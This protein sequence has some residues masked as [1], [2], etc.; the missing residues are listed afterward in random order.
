MTKQELIKYYGDQVELSWMI[1]VCGW[2]GLVFTQNELLA[3]I[4]IPI[5]IYGWAVEVYWS[6]KLEALK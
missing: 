5:M 6:A 3:F 2:G 1:M 4:G